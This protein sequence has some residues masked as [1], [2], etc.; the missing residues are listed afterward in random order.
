MGVIEIEGM[1]FY[2]YHGCFTEEQIVGNKFLV[3]LRIEANCE[4]AEESD[5]INDAVNYQVAYQLIKKEMEVKSHLLENIASRILKS[6]IENL[7]EIDVVTV[8]VAK[9][10]PP[11]GGKIDKTSV[12]LTKYSIDYKHNNEIMCS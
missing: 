2:A 6:L 11:M 8:K 4:K 9:I 1:E 3:D 5:N 7:P 10:N 12:T